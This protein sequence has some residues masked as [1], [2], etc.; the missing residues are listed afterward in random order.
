MKRSRSKHAAN[1][2][3]PPWTW[4]VS[5]LAAIAL[6]V[7]CGGPPQVG[8]NNYR[9]IAGLR[10]AISSRRADWL[11]AAA[12][13]AAERHAAGDLNDEQFAEFEAIIAQARGG[14]WQDAENEVIRLGKAQKPSA[15]EIEQLRGKKANSPKR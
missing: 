4:Q 5:L 8:T 12:K 14:Q 10:T 7:G 9:L 15:E 3:A 6:A 13:Q 2:S 11:E 1:R